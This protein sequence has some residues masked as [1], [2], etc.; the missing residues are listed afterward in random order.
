MMVRTELKPKKVDQAGLLQQLN[1]YQVNSDTMESKSYLYDY[2]IEN[3]NSTAVEN[4]KT[5]DYPFHPTDGFVARLLSIGTEIPE[6]SLESFRSSVE[7]YIQLGKD[8][9]EIVIGTGIKTKSQV[10]QKR[11]FYEYI[12]PELGEVEMALDRFFLDGFKSDFSMFKW[13]HAKESRLKDATIYADCYRPLSEELKMAIDGDKFFLESYTYMT[14]TQLRKTLKFVDSLIDG[15][16]KYLEGKKV[17]R[18]KKVKTPKQLIS[19]F[20]YQTYD[21]GIYSIDPTKIIGTDRLWIFDTVTRY[22]TVYHA[23]DKKG[24][25]VNR[26]TI[27]NF[28]EEKSG[29]KKLIKSKNNDPQELLN[30]ILI[31]TRDGA[32][33]IFNGLTTK[34]SAVHGRMNKNT[35][36][37]KV[38]REGDE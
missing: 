16:K 14:K 27:V 15:C 22:L 10:G 33:N 12:I 8:K 31:S 26:T 23:F 24:L 6:N 38:S 21:D 1:W 17:V 29:R 2:M 35:I 5:L 18:K 7:R 9:V 19:K 36:L 25:T 4:L 13:L 28:D 11:G 32:M 34:A 3:G 37:L 20:L 30:R